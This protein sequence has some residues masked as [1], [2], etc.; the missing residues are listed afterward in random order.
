MAR[1]LKRL[2][3]INMACQWHQEVDGL[4][5]EP[6]ANH[7][8]LLDSSTPDNSE[9]VRNRHPVYCEVGKHD[10]EPEKYHVPEILQCHS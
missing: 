10:K 2:T 5:G 1:F 6:S 3:N 8:L 4:V 7:A 9:L